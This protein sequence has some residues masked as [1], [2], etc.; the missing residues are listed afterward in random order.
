MILVAL[1]SNLPALGYASPAA[2]LEGALAAFERHGL[3]VRGRSSWYESAPVPDVGDPWF[4]NGVVR[5]ETA[6]DPAALLAQLHAIEKGFGRVRA[7]RNAP[8]TLD[9]DLLDYEGRVADGNP[10]LPHPR[11][12]DR[13]F[14]LLPLQEVAPGW[15][16][17]RLG[18]SVDVLIERLD[19]GQRIRRLG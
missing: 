11:L 6:R 7:A 15:V 4:V 10:E 19:P 9:L 17:P 1:G 5:V 14:V 16:H 2:T 12:H 13:A 18:L 8:R 3:A